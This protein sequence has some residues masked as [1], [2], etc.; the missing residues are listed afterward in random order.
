[1]GKISGTRQ[2]KNCPGQFSIAIRASSPERRELIL[3][4]LFHLEGLLWV[5]NG[6]VHLEKIR[7]FRT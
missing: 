2:G 3:G 1:M 7:L 4:P 5:I 6:N